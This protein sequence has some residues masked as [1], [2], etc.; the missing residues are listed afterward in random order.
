VGQTLNKFNVMITE[1]GSEQIPDHSILVWSCL[2]FVPTADVTD[3]PVR[4]IHVP[5]YHVKEI[6]VDF[7]C[8]NDAI[9]DSIRTIESKLFEA[10]DADSAYYE[11]Q[12]LVYTEM[13]LTNKV[14]CATKI[15]Q[16]DNE[17]SINSTGLT[18]CNRRGTEYVRKKRLG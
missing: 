12:R 1:K 3:N 5:T 2:A 9:Q 4:P 8:S 18:N 6:P 14:M 16:K 10:E 7:M 11:F 17:V 13:D 15:D